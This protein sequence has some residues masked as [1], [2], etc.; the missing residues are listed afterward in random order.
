MPL[1]SPLSTPDHTYGRPNGPCSI[2]GCPRIGRVQRGWCET[3]YARWKR[4]GDPL[5]GRITVGERRA[6][7]EEQITRVTDECIDW[8]DGAAKH[9]Y[10]YGILTLNGATREVHVWACQLAHGERPVG[11]EVRHLCGRP[12]CFNPRHLRWGTK[13]ENALD[14]IAHGTMSHKIT[15]EQAAHIRQSV[16]RT[17][18]DLAAE[19]GISQSMVSRIKR[20]A[21]W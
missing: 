20:G 16:G 18:S 17:Q 13:R 6:F 10:G 19:Y 11:M 1:D 5:G 3:H 14:R 8:P 4:H 15:A 21:S 12:S 9:V 2:P 7:F